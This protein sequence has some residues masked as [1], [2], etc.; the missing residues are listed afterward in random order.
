[1]IS[2]SL[3]EKTACPVCLEP[4]GC[5]ACARPGAGHSVCAE[6]PA[7]VRCA[8]GGPDKVRLDVGESEARCRCCGAA[9]PVHR[10]AGYIDLVPRSA[11]GERTRYA[12]HDFHE[13]LRVSDAPLLL[14]ARIKADMMRRM[15]RPP[16]GQALID[17]GCGSG[18]MALYAAE[19]GAQA[20]GLDVAPF[21]LPRAS[22]V[23]DLVLGDLRRLPFRKASFP[24]AF[25]L[26]VLEH[27]DE[28]DLRDA[29]L[30]TRRLLTPRGGFFVYTHALEPGVLAPLLRAL[31]RLARF[32]GRLG[33]LD[34]ER[35]ALRKSD[36]KNA[37]RSHQHF[38]SLC[39]EAGLEVVER[40]YYN[41]LFKNLVEDLLFHMYDHAR[42]S[43]RRGPTETEHHEESSE[44]AAAAMPEPRFEAP[45]G[46]VAVAIGRL[47][48]WLLELD[49]RLLSGIRNGPF[50]AVL[51]PLP[52][53]E[54]P[55]R[56]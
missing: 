31:K 24:G 39:R 1:L 54:V 47:L 43:L 38:D 27:M 45:P 35:E 49:V 4:A 2:P 16:S 50:F 25:S 20:A 18:K 12:D 6:Y 46:R 11:V 29:L 40:R 21:F 34:Y 23:V 37:I 10:G 28:T 7:R 19:T 14:S 8:C 33:L 52:A 32:L 55:P 48:T 22:R 3:I 13:Q 36:H 15:L 30:E 9:Y 42:R 5:A 56:P 51:R 26:D 44:T 41:V 17:L 53:E